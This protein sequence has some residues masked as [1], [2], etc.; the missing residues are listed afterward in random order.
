MAQ[1]MSRLSQHSR[2][3]VKEIKQMLDPT[4][5]QPPQKRATKVRRKETKSGEGSGSGGL[6]SG[7]GRRASKKMFGS[8]FSIGGQQS[9]SGSRQDLRGGDDGSL[10]QKESF[11][12]K[13]IQIGPTGG[14]IGD[15]MDLL[16]PVKENTGTFRAMPEFMY[17][18]VDPNHF[19]IFSFICMLA[20]V[21]QVAAS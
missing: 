5:G 8:S 20:M 12:F 9:E 17:R 11:D 7:L 4:L 15:D 21:L 13:D 16:I 6:G 19:A 10:S 1:S 2:H 18:Y 3:S 14:D